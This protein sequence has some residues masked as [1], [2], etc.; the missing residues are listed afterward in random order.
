M[1]KNKNKKQ[2]KANKDKSQKVPTEIKEDVI[3]KPIEK[4]ISPYLIELNND[5]ARIKSDIEVTTKRKD[6]LQAYLEREHQIYNHIQEKAFAIQKEVIES[7]ERKVVSKVHDDEFVFFDFENNTYRA[8][9][10]N[11]MPEC[12][13]E[14]DNN[15]HISKVS[16]IYVDKE[17]Y[18]TSK[19]F[20]AK[21]EQIKENSHY[22]NSFE[23]IINAS[24]D[25]LSNQNKNTYF[26]MLPEAIDD[27]N[28]KI[29]S[30]LMT[31]NGRIISIPKSISVTYSV[32]DDLKVGERYTVINIDG[33]HPIVTQLSIGKD[34][35]NK[36]VILREGFIKNHSI[37]FNYLLFAEAY[38][39]LFEE[40][41]LVSFSEIEKNS[42]IYNK[43]IYKVFLSKEEVVFFRS[44][45]RISVIFDD[46]IYQKCIQQFITKN[47]TFD[48]VSKIF[49]VSSI[50]G[51]V[52]GSNVFEVNP[53][54]AFEGLKLIRQK[55]INE[56]N[57]IIWKER[58]PKVSLE[59]ID[60][61][62][63]RFKE[64]NLIEENSEAQSIQLTLDSEIELPFK[65]TIT[66]QKN[67]EEYYL[68][69]KR[70]IYLDDINSEKEAYFKH[71]IFPMDHDILVELVVKYNY[72]SESPIKLYARPKKANEAFK[73][74]ENEWVDTH[75]IKVYSGPIYEGHPKEV[76][77]RYNDLFQLTIKGIKRFIDGQTNLSREYFIPKFSDQIHRDY[78]KLSKIYFFLKNTFDSD[79]V[80]KPEF[81][82]MY[83]D[84]GLDKFYESVYD[85]TR[86]KSNL[87]KDVSPN[88]V[89]NY[90][91]GLLVL[92]ADMIVSSWYFDPYDQNILSI[93]EQIVNMKKTRTY[94]KLSRCIASNEDDVYGV[95][96]KLTN[97]LSDY[98]EDKFQVDFRDKRIE[99]IRTLSQNCW[100]NRNWM[101]LFYESS[102]GAKTVTLITQYILEYLKKEEFRPDREYRDIMEFLVC[103]TIVKNYN[104]ALFNPNKSATKELLITVKKS[105]DIA[106]INITD[107]YLKSRLQMQQDQ[108]PLFGYH[109]Y[110]YILIMILSG[111]GQINLVGYHD[112]ERG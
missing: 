69:L 18:S 94:I 52:L 26:C 41:Y 91:Q 82:E 102:N 105:Y 29:R 77:L 76:V 95:F 104:K 109:N 62:T 6:E 35:E 68:P 12:Y 99:Y 74:L 15:L 17:I 49:L 57:P 37:K 71:K 53:S 5:V 78:D 36:K 87:Y 31:K 27:F 55:M 54:V 67:K 89:K 11:V 58:L 22:I 100:F 34:K 13:L 40:K 1:A 42:L 103:L 79:N 75:E 21:N 92:V 30:K 80:Q 51:L 72:L 48:N 39:K 45:N 61:N 90:Q 106:R 3:V 73:E 2:N 60:D 50:P 101:K 83:Y 84:F 63:G 8:S 85:V 111:E 7:N 19:M 46:E 28:T 56:K 108:G 14:E 107:D 43:H 38:V 96:A 59:V 88:Q 10:I 110:I 25:L 112:D 24:I 32:L 86:V 97:K 98:F 20:L 33:M 70:D 81:E 64:I 65:G 9:R 47:L 4:V 23:K 44:K 93:Y 66:L 16:G